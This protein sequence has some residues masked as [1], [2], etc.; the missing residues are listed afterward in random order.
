MATERKLAAIAISDE[1]GQGGNWQRRSTS[2]T[3]FSRR[4]Y[5]YINELD[6]C[7]QTND[8]PDAAGLR[9]VAQRNVWR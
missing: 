1:A 8:A 7:T 5:K 4:R 9:E 3:S 6:V 2:R